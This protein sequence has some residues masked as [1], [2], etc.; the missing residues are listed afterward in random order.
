LYRNKQHT[1]LL[2]LLTGVR[3]FLLI[4][5]VMLAGIASAGGARGQAINSDEIIALDAN[6]PTRSFPHIWEEMFGSGR[7]VLSLRQSYREDLTSVKKITGFKYIRFHA[8]FHDEMGVYDKMHR[9]D[10]STTSPT[11]I[12]SMTGFLKMASNRSLS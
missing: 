1:G 2:R 3:D 5:V 12:K 4:A 10:R 8:I 9:L 11:S 6:A 7:A